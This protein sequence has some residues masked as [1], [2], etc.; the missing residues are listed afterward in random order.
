MFQTN[1]RVVTNFRALAETLT[2]WNIYCLRSETSLKHCGFRCY[3]RY[4]GSS[5]K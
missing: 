2:V 1:E 5:L 3:D 4:I